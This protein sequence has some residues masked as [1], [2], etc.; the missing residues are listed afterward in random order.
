MTRE[1]LARSCCRLAQDERHRSR[2]SPLLNVACPQQQVITMNKI[3][4]KANTR[5]SYSG[6]SCRPRRHAE[7]YARESQLSSLHTRPR[8]NDI[9]EGWSEMTGRMQWWWRGSFSGHR[10]RRGGRE[11]EKRGRPMRIMKEPPQPLDLEARAKRRRGRLMLMIMKG[12]EAGPSRRGGRRKRR[13]ESIQTSLQG[14]E[15][16]LPA[17]ARMMLDALGLRQGYS[18]RMIQHRLRPHRRRP[19]PP[20][21][22]HPVR[23]PHLRR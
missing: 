6:H 3:N 14:M 12:R 2:P 23:R 5:I 21:L 20:V 7:T 16:T 11:R 9:V 8:C 13:G 18:T 17:R 4:F 1:A 19:H 22:V 15:A 10:E